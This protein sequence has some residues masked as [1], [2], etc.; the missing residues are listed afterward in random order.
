MQAAR[1]FKLKTLPLVLSTEPEFLLI[2]KK[3]YAFYKT[4]YLKGFTT[5]KEDDG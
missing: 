4:Y 2:T 5:I 1:F 3:L